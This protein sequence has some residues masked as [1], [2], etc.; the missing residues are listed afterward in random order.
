MRPAQWSRGVV[1]CATAV[2]VDPRLMNWREQTAV[3][4]WKQLSWQG[5]KR[6]K[7]KHWSVT[8]VPWCQVHQFNRCQQPALE[9]GGFLLRYQQ[10]GLHQAVA[11]EFL[12]MQIAGAM[13]CVCFCRDTPVLLSCCNFLQTVF[14][15][16]SVSLPWH[17]CIPN[18]TGRWSSLRSR[19]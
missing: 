15:D 9:G 18:G 8:T 1:P 7:P 6:A 16:A 17:Y 4:G 19:V 12:C 3:T 2:R 5:C 11:G 14:F 13:Y 10:S